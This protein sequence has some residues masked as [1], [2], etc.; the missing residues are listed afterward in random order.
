MK[1]ARIKVISANDFGKVRAT[2]CANTNLDE[3]TYEDNCH[4]R[5]RDDRAQRRRFLSKGNEVIKVSRSS[6]D[7]RADIGN[8]ASLEEMFA[9]VGISDAI[10]CA[11]GSAAFKPLASLSDDDFEMSLKN[12]LM[13]QVNVVRAGSRYIVPGVSI[14]IT[15]GTLAQEPIPGG[16]AVSLVNAALE[17]FTRA[18]ALELE[19]ARVRVNVVSPPWVKETLI[20]YKMDPSIGLAAAEVAKAYLESVESALT[21]QVIKPSVPRT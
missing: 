12:K 8:K 15:S 10:V 6:E 18:A 1:I 7:R 5:Y 14:T 20:A 2:A 13:G 19:S 21:G 4:R 16:A 3:G 11:A 9:K 17:G